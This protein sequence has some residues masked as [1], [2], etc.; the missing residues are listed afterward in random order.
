[1]QTTLGLL[2]LS[3][4]T[5]ALGTLG[6]IGGASLL[7]PILVLG[8]LKPQL[9]APLGLLAVGAGSLAASPQQ[10]GNGLVHHRL[11]IVIEIT[12]SA[13]AAAGALAA[14][15]LPTRVLGLILGT[16]ALAGGIASARDRSVSTTSEP[17][18]DAETPGEFPGSLSGQYRENDGMVPY[19]AT[20]VPAGMTVTAL[21]GLVSGLSGVGGGF[22]KVPAMTKIMKVPLRVAAAT[23]TYTV[24]ITAASALLVSIAVHRVQFDT[25]APVVLGGLI[26][27]LT[28][29]TVQ[30]RISAGSLRLIISALLVVIGLVVIGRQL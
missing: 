18:L 14:G 15:V 23:S 27:G 8:G 2:L 30:Y 11:G 29:A 26:G 7:V 19:T 3:F 16:T 25:A 20:N 6:G 4:G 12:A 1:M 9:A 28:G 21:A 5:C 22:I 24:G 10:T 13:G 17:I